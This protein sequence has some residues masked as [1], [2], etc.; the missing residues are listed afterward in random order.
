MKILGSSAIPKSSIDDKYKQLLEIWTINN[1]KTFRD[2]LKYYS[3]LDIGP[4]VQGI[5]AFKKYFLHKNVDVFKDNVSVP[6]IARQN[7][8]KCGIKMGASFSLNDSLDRD[9]YDTIKENLT[10]GPSIIF[11]RKHIVGETYIRE[12]HSRPCRSSVGYDANSLY[13]YAIC[14]EMPVGRYIRR[15]A[16]EQFKPRDFARCSYVMYDWMNWLNHS[17]STCIQRKLNF[18]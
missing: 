14:Q 12:D 10:G 17:Q 8:Y 11:C 18:G 16:G 13:L 4:F 5:A 9:I 7:L 2:F 3:E 15:L 1:M 6:G